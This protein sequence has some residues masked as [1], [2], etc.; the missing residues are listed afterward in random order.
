M[1]LRCIAGPSYDKGSHHLLLHL[2][3][4]RIKLCT[5]LSYQPDHFC[6]RALLPARVLL[7]G[8]VGAY[9]PSYCS[10][11][12]SSWVY[13]SRKFTADML[14]ERQERARRCGW[15]SVHSQWSSRHHNLLQRYQRCCH[16]QG[17]P[18]YVWGRPSAG[19]WHLYAMLR[20]CTLLWSR[21]EMRQG[22]W[23]H[24]QRRSV[25]SSGSR[26]LV[27]LPRL[28]SQHWHALLRDMQ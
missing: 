11:R 18:Y 9:N 17:C 19:E 16:L 13:H 28:D 26:Q 10:W 1:T 2:T 25:C 3:D 23:Q 15:R 7:P 5:D 12:L 8:N 14:P 22:F 27:L 6:V 20:R 24:R 4:D 21:N